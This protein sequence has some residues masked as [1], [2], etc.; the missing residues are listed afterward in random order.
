MDPRALAVTRIRTTS[1]SLAHSFGK[2]MLAL[3]LVIGFLTVIDGARTRSS[4]P[5]RSFAPPSWAPFRESFEKVHGRIMDVGVSA[6]RPCS[7]WLR[8]ID[9][10]FGGVSRTAGGSSF[11]RHRRLRSMDR[12]VFSTI[13]DRFGGRVRFFISEA[14]RRWTAMWLSGSM[15]SAGLCSRGTG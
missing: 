1:G 15:R 12:L 4:K 11:R 3:P 8:A 14:W 5:G 6:A 10:G 7:V 13:R 9:V 2:V